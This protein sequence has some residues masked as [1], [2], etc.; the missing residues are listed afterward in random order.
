[1]K[2]S[3]YAASISF[4]ASLLEPTHTE[5]ER[6]KQVEE[7]TGRLG[8]AARLFLRRTARDCGLTTLPGATIYVGTRGYAE[9]VF[10]PPEDLT[11]LLPE[12]VDCAGGCR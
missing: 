3:D 2:A 7:T 9:P 10:L 5:R 12:E 1:M 8:Y 11:V 4:D 6:Q